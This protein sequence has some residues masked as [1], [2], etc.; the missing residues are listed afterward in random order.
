MGEGELELQETS[1]SELARMI[2]TEGMMEGGGAPR[3]ARN[4]LCDESGR[5]R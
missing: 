2:L 5:A 3:K 4:L 1:W